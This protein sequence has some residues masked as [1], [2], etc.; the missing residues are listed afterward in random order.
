MVQG[1]AGYGLRRGRGIGAGGRGFNSGDKPG[2]GPGGI[3]V[4]PKCGYEMPHTINDPCNRY[5][6]PKCGT[7]MTKD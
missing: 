4:C 2:S 7:T 1:K 3:C 6:C 5:V